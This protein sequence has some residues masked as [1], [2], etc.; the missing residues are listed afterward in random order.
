LKEQSFVC[1]FQH[2]LTYFLLYTGVCFWSIR[3]CSG[4]SWGVNPLHVL[5]E[6]TT[7]I[8]GLLAGSVANSTVL[9]ALLAIHST[10]Q[11]NCSTVTQQTKEL[12]CLWMST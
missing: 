7:S 8:G 10:W 3:R 2:H 4:R 6:V 11:N 12:L 5:S 1:C 9:S